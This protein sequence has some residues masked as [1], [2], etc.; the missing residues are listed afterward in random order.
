MF[1]RLHHLQGVILVRSIQGALG[2]GHREG[3]TN[4]GKEV[5][6]RGEPMGL[7]AEAEGGWARI[8]PDGVVVGWGVA[9]AVAMDM[10]DRLVHAG[11]TIHVSQ[12]HILVSEITAGAQLSFPV[13]LVPRRGQEY[14]AVSVLSTIVQQTLALA[15]KT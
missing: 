13:V 15:V 10:V 8:I 14:R 9:V 2:S 5:R 1:L 6:G 3:W 7:P 4:G 12:Q 11:L